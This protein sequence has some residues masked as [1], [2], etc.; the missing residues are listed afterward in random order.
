MRILLVDDN[1]LN[2]A[3]LLR[4]LH[5]RFAD[6][7]DPEQP[8]IALTDSTTALDLLHGTM[9][10]TDAIQA[11][12]P[13]T[14]QRTMPEHARVHARANAKHNPTPTF[15]HIM[16][17]IHMPAISGLSMARRIRGLPTSSVNRHAKLL[18]CTT[19]VREE[20][21]RLYRAGGFDGLIEKPVRENTLR[22]FFD[23]L[24]EEDARRKRQ[25]RLFRRAEAMLVSLSSSSSGRDSDSD[26]KAGPALPDNGDL[27]SRSSHNVFD[28]GGGG[29]DQV[30]KSS[31]VVGFASVLTSSAGTPSEPSPA[32]TPSDDCSGATSPLPAFAGTGGHPTLTQ[33][34]ARSKSVGAEPAEAR[35]FFLAL[36]NT[37]PLILPPI[38]ST[39]PMGATA[40]ET[41][42]LCRANSPAQMSCADGRSHVEG[43]VIRSPHYVTS[44]FFLG[45]HEGEED[46]Q[47]GRE[48]IVPSAQFDGVAESQSSPSS[49]A[50]PPLSR[51]PA[52]R[53]HTRP[54][55]LPSHIRQVSAAPID[56]RDLAEV[57]RDVD[58]D[59]FQLEGSY[60]DASNQV[61][62][63]ISGAD[64]N[65]TEDELAMNG[66]EFDVD[67]EG[68][69]EGS[70]DG[71]GGEGQV[72]MLSDANECAV[73][74]SHGLDQVISS[75]VNSQAAAGAH[76]NSAAALNT[77]LRSST[78]PT[79]PSHFTGGGSD[80]GVSYNAT[81]SSPTSSPASTLSRAT[82]GGGGGVRSSHVRHS[83]PSPATAAH[84]S[85]GAPPPSARGAVVM[86][87]E[88]ELALE[89]ESV[90]VSMAAVS[91]E[92]AAARPRAARTELLSSRMRPSNSAPVALLPAPAMYPAS[93]GAEA[94]DLTAHD[95][96]PLLE[97][98]MSGAVSE[99]NSIHAV[100]AVSTDSVFGLTW[101]RGMVSPSPTMSDMLAD[102]PFGGV[103][104]PPASTMAHDG[105]F[106]R[107]SD[108]SGSSSAGHTSATSEQH[109]GPAEEHHYQQEQK[110]PGAGPGSQFAALPIL[111]DGTPA[112]Q[113]QQQQHRS[114]SKISKLRQ[115]RPNSIVLPP[116]RFS[117]DL[118]GS[119]SGLNL[120]LGHHHHSAASHHSIRGDGL[121]SPR[122]TTGERLLSSGDS[123]SSHSGRICAS[124]VKARDTLFTRTS[125]V[126]MRSFAS[127]FLAKPGSRSHGA[128]GGG[129]AGA[130]VSQSLPC[131][132]PALSDATVVQLKLQD[133]GAAG[134]GGRDDAEDATRSVVGI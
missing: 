82:A 110:E 32:S 31:S 19:A 3:L 98:A 88:R 90:G 130:G 122:G 61:I 59:S 116:F 85:Y 6:E 106:R 121:V 38:S 104:T 37:D 9:T 133:C 4:L 23:F 65:L 56:L 73:L 12:T 114:L 118:S 132:P 128:V 57:K 53:S 62:R 41:N 64:E 75:E 120:P 81:A 8:P 15:T 69:C 55:P 113:Q 80:R 70:G 45:R 24:G 34:L 11:A 101:T 17:D 44:G 119:P 131:T 109:L 50:P 54:P 87:L 134:D 39:C 14:V 26:A 99:S 5:R 97:E 127:L 21:Q 125:E 42:K 112:R 105:F 18:A 111:T 84:F 107:E 49:E 74:C 48:F 22:A 63:W 27:G 46:G 123:P 2:L 124:M 83:N 13:M 100:D 58:L 10:I 47:A 108:I 86:D 52:L 36:H 28:G 33:R 20:E 67:V 93:T 129:G 126:C 25:E 91:V 79:M 66:G 40:A 94:I 102:G 89:L 103:L 1:P 68:E 95:E 29:G 35:S 60:F 7:L 96:V 51:S 92:A 77:L 78:L 72:E 76:N 16:L 71:D 117:I 43:E 30:T 115:R